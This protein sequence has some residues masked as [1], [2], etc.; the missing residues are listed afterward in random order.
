MDFGKA[1]AQLS[2][3]P[4][5]VGNPL[6]FCGGQCAPCAQSKFV[7][8]TPFVMRRAPEGEALHGQRGRF[9][10][11]PGPPGTITA[12]RWMQHHRALSPTYHQRLW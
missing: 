3:N 11:D 9:H 1:S 12:P 10:L 5:N 2:G 8:F 6:D 4:S 7:Y